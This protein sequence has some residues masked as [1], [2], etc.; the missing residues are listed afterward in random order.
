MKCTL[1]ISCLRKNTCRQTI[2]VSLKTDIFR[3]LYTVF[4][5]MK[6]EDIKTLGEYHHAHARKTI[7]SSP[8]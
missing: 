4:I 2:K 7:P 6:V 1:Y 8:Q 5:Y 3:K